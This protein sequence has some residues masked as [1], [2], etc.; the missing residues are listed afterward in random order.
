MFRHINL[1]AIRKYYDNMIKLCLSAAHYAQTYKAVFNISPVVIH[2]N[3]TFYCTTFTVLI[4]FHNNCFAMCFFC[5][6]SNLA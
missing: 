2:F 3:C 1:T 4:L 5:G 6:Y